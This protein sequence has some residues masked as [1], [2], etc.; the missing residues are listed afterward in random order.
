MLLSTDCMFSPK[1]KSEARETKRIYVMMRLFSSKIGLSDYVTTE[2]ES[3][4]IVAL[5]NI[6]RSNVAQEKQ[7]LGETWVKVK[8]D[9]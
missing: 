1:S 9:V 3:E 4:D 6:C 2:T 8:Q 5:R 7:L